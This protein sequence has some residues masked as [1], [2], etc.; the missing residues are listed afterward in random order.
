MNLITSLPIGTFSPPL[1]SLYVI[2]GS[3]AGLV[4]LVVV[5]VLLL[6]R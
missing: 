4:L 2:G 5:I 3:T 1:A 6:R